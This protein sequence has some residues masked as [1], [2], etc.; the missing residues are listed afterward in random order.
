MTFERSDLGNQV[1]RVAGRE[2]GTLRQGGGEGRCGYE[3]KH[4]DAMRSG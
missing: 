3:A 1:I 4:G 2:R